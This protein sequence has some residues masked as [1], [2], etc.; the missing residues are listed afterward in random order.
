MHARAGDRGD[1]HH[2][3]P[4]VLQFLDQPARDHDRREEV[5]V[6]NV[7][8]GL[9]VGVHGAE[10]AAAHRLRRDRGVVDQRMQLVIVQPLPDLRDRAHGVV[11][12]AEI[13][14]DVIFRPGAPR[15]NLRKRM[16]REGDDAPAGG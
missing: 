9:D 12:A 3:A 6:E 7:G 11:M 13:D 15:A 8:P 5:D 14:L 4:G 2:R 10:P 16:P 1:V